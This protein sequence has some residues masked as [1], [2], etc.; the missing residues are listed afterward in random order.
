MSACTPKTPENI[1][2][3]FLDAVELPNPDGKHLNY[4]FVMPR[5]TTQMNSAYRMPYGFCLVSSALKASG[6]TVFTLN[7]NYKENPYE[8]LQETIQNNNIDVLTG[9]LSGQYTILKE[10]LDT[11][12]STNPNVITC[13]GGGIITA[14]PSVA[15]I[16]LET[17]DYGVVGEGEITVN[18]L[19]YALENEKNAELVA[20]VVTRQGMISATRAGVSDLDILPFPDYIG[21]E[22]H[23]LLKDDLIRYRV[24]VSDSAVPIATARSCPYNCTFCFHTCDKN[25]RKRSFENVRKELDWILN[26]YPSVNLVQFVDEMFGKDI[27]FLNKIANYM[28]EKNLKYQIFQRVDAVSKHMLQLLKDSGCQHIFFGV[29]SA[30]NR[31]LKSMNKNITVK[32]IEY[33]FDLS[34]EVGLDAR[35]FIIFGDVEET[36]ETIR[37]SLNWWK[38]HL[39]YDIM[40][41]WIFAFPGI[42]LYK[43]ACE[44]G[45]IPDRVKYLK[46]GDMQINLTKMSDEI[47]WE[48]VQ[49]VLLFQILTING[50]DIEFDDMN[51]VMTTLKRRLDNICKEHI[52]AIWPAKFDIIA[53]LNGISPNFVSSKNV[54]FVN[55]DPSS[56]YVAACERF[57]KQ[58]YTPEEVLIA[59]GVDMVF[60]ANGNR[61]T[62]N[63]VFTQIAEEIQE[64]YVSIKYLITIIDCLKVGVI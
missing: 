53:M 34:L 19:A 8:L 63:L 28:K 47:Y 4:L 23:L 32:Q 3:Q 50:A 64:R 60:F 36:P 27:K 17:A 14:D 40:L 39:R 2:Q 13:V 20:G 44:R 43:I 46:D 49:K 48:M 9:G 18:A 16:A 7:L 45:I 5:F 25:Y 10:I 35:G 37:N 22:F 41:N 62:G 12:K 15:M 56:S 26:N 42:H 59:K 11:V 51:D 57:G 21:F 29:E 55:V 24:T 54:F 30:D 1:T 58:V 61:A 33:A 6:R 38:K 31:I 52:I